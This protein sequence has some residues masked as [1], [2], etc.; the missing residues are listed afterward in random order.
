[1]ANYRRI[2]LLTILLIAFLLLVTI[3][4]ILKKQS[5]PHRAHLKVHKY[6]EG[7]NLELSVYESSGEGPGP[8]LLIFGGIHGDEVAGYLAAERYINVEVKRGKL[9]I[10]PR[11]NAPAISKGTR[12]GLGGD[13]NRLF[14]LPQNSK[15]PPDAKVVNLAQS[16]IK[17]AD[18]VLNLHQADGFYS[19]VWVSPER[20]PRKWGQCNVIDAPVF[21][22]PNGERLEILSFAQK[23]VDSAN[24]KIEDSKYHFQVNN[25]N[26][27]SA[28]SLYKEQRGSLTYY[29]L[30]KEHKIALG[31]DVTRKCSLSQAISFL[32]IFIN[33]VIR[34]LD[35]QGKS[36]PSEKWQEIEREIEK[37]SK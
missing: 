13:M 7:T 21:D 18:Y 35:M 1:M 4:P 24:A 37:H 20:N 28:H 32:T 23:L 33:S 15:S 27:A 12:H 30:Y 36:L 31:V 3:P 9:L 10:V 16:L 22:L 11:L 6:F 25:T 5:H 19:P 34:E 29:A 8:V 2:A 14:H 17:Q 26:T